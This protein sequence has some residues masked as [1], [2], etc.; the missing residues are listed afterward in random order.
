LVVVANFGK[1]ALAAATARSTS[2]D[3]PTEISV[4]A[5]SVA[6]SITGMRCAS[7]GATQRPSM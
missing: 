2:A 5:S 6:G 4:N 1:A 3:E 7:T